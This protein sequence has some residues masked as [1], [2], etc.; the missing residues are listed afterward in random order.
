[1]AQNFEILSNKM[2]EEQLKTRD[3]K[4]DA[5]FEAMNNV[6]RHLFV[7]KKLQNY[8][9]SDSPLPIG[10]G[11]TISQPYIVAFM[12]EQLE[13]APGMKVLEIGTGSGYQAAI[14]AYL[15]CEVYTIELLKELAAEAKKNLA[16]HNFNA[17]VKHGNG[18]MG[19]SEE[20]PFDAIIVTA[21]PDYI[22]EKLIE[23]LK[24]GGK[25]IIPV[26]EVHSVQ[27]LKL[28]TKKGEK[29]IEKNLLPV[30]F[31]PM[32]DKTI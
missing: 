19:W 9:Y 14:L 21:A 2:V 5:V 28:I 26:G 1:M 31:V 6:Q 18:Y 7:S 8:A 3:I 13:L 11:Q 32:V 24:D 23:Q 17:K 27:L 16:A 29:V 12:T 30:R 20:A 22:P 4:S 25:M 10:M 15:G